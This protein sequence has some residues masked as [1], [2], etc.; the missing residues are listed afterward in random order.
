MGGRER[1]RIVKRKRERGRRRGKTE[2]PVVAGL[3]RKHCCQS[4]QL[5]QPRPM[6]TICVRSHSLSLSGFLPLALSLCAS[7]SLSFAA[8]LLICLHECLS[9]LEMRL[10]SFPKIKTQRTEVALPRPLPLK[11]WNGIVL[12]RIA[13]G[14]ASAR[15]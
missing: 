15:M 14:L 6:A 11:I 1:E 10:K 12:D 13:H 3:V 9:H 8:L 2:G 7:L 5:R 4:P